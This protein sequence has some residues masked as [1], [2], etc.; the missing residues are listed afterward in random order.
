MIRNIRNS[1]TLILLCSLLRLF[2]TSIENFPLI[3]RILRRAMTTVDRF[4]GH[5]ADSAPWPAS[6]HGKIKQTSNSTWPIHWGFQARAHWVK[7]WSIVLTALCGNSVVTC[8]SAACITCLGNLAALKLPLGLSNSKLYLAVQIKLW[9][10]YSTSV[11][12][13][14][15]TT[16][17]TNNHGVTPTSME[18]HQQP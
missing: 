15:P 3:F 7:F 14:S 16:S 6:V 10:I 1:S 2:V 8:G 13:T 12:V 9:K 4:S 5:A 11:W 17:N 18:Q